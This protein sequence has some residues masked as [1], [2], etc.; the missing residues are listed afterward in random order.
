MRRILIAA[1]AIVAV[2]GLISSA[3]AIGFDETAHH[4][5]QGAKRNRMWPWPYV[6]ADR[7][8]VREP[9]GV[10]INNGWRR[11]NLL[12]PHHFNDK[13]EQLTTAGELRVQWIMSQAPEARR[14]IFIERDISPD[15]T[16]KRMVTARD[17]ATRLA[18]NGTSPEINETNIAS[19][20]RPASVVD[21]M[22]VRFQESMPAP[23]LP[24]DTLTIGTSN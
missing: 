5:K 4:I 22:N 11:Q 23:T 15:V 3:S 13:S 12:G 8:A 2:G 20:G 10:M 17:Y 24:A 18:I 19:E 7:V 1:A 14:Q 6:C 9:F 21:A 16:A